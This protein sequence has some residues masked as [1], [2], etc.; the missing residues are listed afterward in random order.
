MP[1]GVSIAPIIPP[2]PTPT[3]PRFREP[4]VAQFTTW[5]G[6]PA[7][8][9]CSMLS[10][11]PRSPG[12]LPQMTAGGL[13][14]EETTELPAHERGAVPGS[15]GTPTHGLANRLAYALVA[16]L[17][18]TTV[19][20]GNALV[21][22][23]AHQLRQLLDLS[24]THMAWVSTSYVMAAVS[25]NLLLIKVRQQYGLRRFALV[26]LGLYA[27]LALTQVFVSGLGALILV[28]AISGFVS[29]ALIPLCLFSMMQAFPASWRLRGLVLAIG[30]TQ[31]AIPLA[32]VLSPA[33]LASQGWRALF[34]LEA[35]LALLSLSAVGM[36]RLPPAERV[37]V[38]R[39]LD[40]L[41][42]VLMGGGLAL[43]AAVLGLGRWEGWLRAPWIV[44]A[45]C[46]AVP[47]LAAAGAL[48][49]ARQTPL[50]NLRWLGRG[51]VARFAVAILLVRMVLAEHDVVIGV[52]RSAGGTAQQLSMLS[53]ATLGGAVVGVL[54]STLTVNADKIALPMMLAAGI[55]AL[56]A[57][58][59]SAADGAHHLPR[60]YLSQ[61]A[62]AFAGTFFL[63]PALVLGIT[64]AL[65]HGSRE[66]ISFIVLF[67]ILNAF[68]A[69]AGS[70]VL[71][72]HIEWR[73]AA[74]ASALGARLDT[75]LLAAALA[76]ATTIYLA[77]L[78]VLRIRCKLAQLRAGAAAGPPP[79]A[80]AVTSGSPSAD[81]GWRPPR[82]G[83][84]LALA[85]AATALLGGA[86]VLA[87]WRV[88]DVIR[89]A[90]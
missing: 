55:I 26:S 70:A 56:A 4:G 14:D 22:V 43:L 30:V 17:V 62:V 87:A 71:E 53:M 18:G 45:L 19:G 11:P 85:F 81:S 72:S 65:Q 3:Q 63:G 50:L 82:P 29:V 79:A 74:G 66:L 41:T 84:A 39:R 76:G 13:L 40:L 86:L 5:N 2:W 75:M 38:F 6:W 20:L 7:V 23:N 15:P 78:L 35:G 80:A 57:L 83:S 58:V 52:M 44:V 1:G 67:G 60:L 88:V 90:G 59:S 47:A 9:T 69:L 28:R 27:V 16:L 36:Q 73:Q 46:V 37:R 34:L 32:H 61:A 25:A 42:F 8:Y 77:V 33:L 10:I 89:P 51:D 21:T 31:C 64:S 12:H 68:G 48:E 49:A 24:A 54:I